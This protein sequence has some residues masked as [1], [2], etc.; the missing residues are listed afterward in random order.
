MKGFDPTSCARHPLI[1]CSRFVEREGRFKPSNNP[2]APLS[3]LVSTREDDIQVGMLMCFRTTINGHLDNPGSFGD[4]G[5]I[6]AELGSN[7]LG[8]VTPISDM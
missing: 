1:S 5:W 4:S 8:R 2:I 6:K 3:S 7:P